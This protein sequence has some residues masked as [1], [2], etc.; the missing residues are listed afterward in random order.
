M[1]IYELTHMFFYHSGELIYSPKNL[2]L[3]YSYDSVKKAIQ[4]YCMQPGFCDNERG[5]SVR[6]RT[7]LGNIVD[8]TVFEVIVYL[9]S[10]DY[11]FEAEIELGLFGCEESAYAK[12]DK[13]C[14]ENLALVNYEKL[15]VE[16]IVNKCIVEKKEWAEGFSVSW[17]T[18]DKVVSSE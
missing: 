12:L 1:E 17:K 5:F 11:E 8:H 15:V 2:G 16:K 4:Y 6:E 18:V 3:F 14:A 10:L 9:N 13:Y 7:V